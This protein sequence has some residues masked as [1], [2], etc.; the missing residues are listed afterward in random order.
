M[1]GVGSF[2]SHI[3]GG[4]YSEGVRECDFQKDIS[5]YERRCNRRVEEI[6]H[7]RAAGPVL[8]TNHYS[9]DQIKKNGMGW[10]CGTNG[11]SEGCT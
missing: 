4:I 5:A 10:A 8:F 7:L 3:Q 2:V 11:I 6:A 1:F 9:G